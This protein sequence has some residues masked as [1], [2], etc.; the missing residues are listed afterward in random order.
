MMLVLVRLCGKFC[1]V[2]GG[3]NRHGRQLNN[4]I[5]HSRFIITSKS[6][7]SYHN[8]DFDY[9]EWSKEADKIYTSQ[10]QTIKI[11]S[12]NDCMENNNEKY[13]W[14]NFYE[15][16]S[17]GNVYKARNYLFSE[18]QKWLEEKKCI[19]ILEVGCGHGCSIEGL[20]KHLR[21][22]VQIV[23]TDYST[24]AL[25]ILR[26]NTY[27]NESQ[28]TSAT[29]D[30]TLPFER[31]VSVITP[32]A[33]LCIFVLSAIKPKYHVKCL[34]NIADVLESDGVILFRDYGLH[35]MTMYRHKLKYSEKSFLRND[36]TLVYY[37][38]L[39]Y[40]R[41]IAALSGL[42]V[43]S[44]EYATVENKNR[45]SNKCMKRVFVHAV[46]RKSKIS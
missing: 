41:E 25:A 16:H 2:L 21:P 24:K 37:F 3:R 18:F 33:V 32:N 45:M 4:H 23:A 30:V 35:D 14:N 42:S 22:C 36:K 17:T 11:L 7:H 43:E 34:K 26:M 19:V 15:T 39:D 9:N 29:W 1:V 12:D 6:N 46:F 27:Y 20:I 5:L 40:L 13:H 44:L 10:N 38:D 31:Q 8:N 28:I